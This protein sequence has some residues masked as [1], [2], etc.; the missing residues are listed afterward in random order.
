MKKSVPGKRFGESF[1]RHRWRHAPDVTLPA[2]ERSCDLH[3]GD[4]GP[5]MRSEERELVLT[6]RAT[7]LDTTGRAS[8]LTVWFDCPSC[9]V[10][11]KARV[12]SLCGRVKRCACEAMF[13]IGRSLAEATEIVLADARS[14]SLVACA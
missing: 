13:Y 11:T 12:W 14:T 1:Q 2:N 6:H 5:Q 10:Q 4:M 7:E 9:A 3:Q 8:Q